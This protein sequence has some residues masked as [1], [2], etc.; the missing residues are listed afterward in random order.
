VELLLTRDQAAATSYA[1]DLRAA[2]IERRELDNAVAEEAGA[3]VYCNCDPDSDVAIVVGKEDWHVGVIGIVASK[4]V[5]KFHRPSILL[6]IDS[7]GMARG[8]GRSIP[9][10]HLLE[11]LNR[12]ADVLEGFGGHAA[13]A[14]LTL[15]SENIDKFRK[16]FNSVVREMVKPDDL[17]PLVVA[18]AEVSLTQLTPKFFRIIKEMEPFGPGNMRPVFLCRDLQ[19]R[20]PPRNVGS[21]HLKMCVTAEGSVMDA[22]GFNLGDRIADVTKQGEF[23]LA[24]SLE[25]NEW[26][27][28]INLQMKVR[29]VSL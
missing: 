23:G 25:E 17:L 13:A 3:W 7:D 21:N 29:G 24:F 10:L 11:A 22:I 16:K 18:D 8:S 19:H 26:N 4:M 12:C 15:K 1:K 6:S 28:K 20:T 9:G 2:N 27:G 5:E 14:G